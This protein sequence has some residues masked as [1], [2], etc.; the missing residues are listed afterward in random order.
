VSLIRN[1]SIFV[2]W[3]T[4]R[5]LKWLAKA[6]N[7]ARLDFTEGDVENG[8]RKSETTADWIADQLLNKIIEQEHPEIVQLENNLDDREAEVIG[9]ITENLIWAKSKEGKK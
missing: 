7:V 4:R 6:K 8:G 9:R 5:R 1:D 2:N 3:R